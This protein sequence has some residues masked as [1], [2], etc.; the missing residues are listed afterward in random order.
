[1]RNHRS[2]I[3]TVILLGAV[4]LPLTACS[5]G[6]PAAAETVTVTAAPPVE[7]TPTETPEA[8]A[9]PVESA[10]P[11]AEAPAVVETMTM[12]AVVGV[13]LQLAQDTLQA[14]GSYVLDQTDASGLGRVQVN[15]SNWQV[16]GQ[17]P[18][19]GTVV[20]VDT[21]VTLSAV[22]LDETCP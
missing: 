19:P 17:D 3:A 10:A 2:T 22:K 1:M 4:A 7:E 12:P 18:A 8:P 6:T 13:N 5:S 14:A 11:V 21:M 15:D 20:P 9:A 16:C